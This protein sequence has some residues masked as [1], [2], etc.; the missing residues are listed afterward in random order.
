MTDK[1]NIILFAAH[2]P[3]GTNVIKPVIEY[4]TGLP[5]WRV[6]LL[7]LG[8]ARERITIPGA[9]YLD[10]PTYPTPGFP[11]EVSVY[12]EDVK[13][14]LHTI[15]P[16]FVFTA[17]SFNSNLERL[18]IR[19]AN[20]RQI[21][22]A[23]ILD[24]WSNYSQRFS[25]DGIVVYP[26]V[27][28]VADVKMAQEC[29]EAVEGAA[30]VIISGNPHLQS[31]TTTIAKRRTVMNEKN[32]LRRV[33]FF[34]ENIHHYYP[35]K[36]VNELT[37]V[38]DLIQYLH[39]YAWLGEVLIRP[40]PMESRDVWSSFIK[41][42]TAPS[43]GIQLGLDVTPFNDVLTDNFIALGLTSMALLETAV[44]GI[45][46]FSY[47]IGVPQSDGYFMLPYQEYGI[48]QVRDAAEI[49]SMLDAKMM[50]RQIDETT[51]NFQVIQTLIANNLVLN[52][53]NVGTML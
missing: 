31:L 12:P 20:E 15:T 4:Y 7:L 37:I 5:E 40:H 53:D 32:P 49:P 52:K 2:D 44:C 26:Q 33:R 46:T 6:V 18:V 17:T 22:T 50:Y 38:T 28:F 39:R 30:Q 9:E 11:N 41:T 24:Y 47:Q 14:L 19:F 23:S 51:A 16:D 36:T 10:I 34:S 25:Y 21:P 1:Q 45:P 8:P 43:Q 35:H 27:I 48:V 3:G 42:H 29:K 13:N